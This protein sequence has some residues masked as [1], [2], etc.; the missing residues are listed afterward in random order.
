MPLLYGIQTVTNRLQP[1]HL[2]TYH[3][4][5]FINFQFFSP[6][7]VDETKTH[8]FVICIIL[9]YLFPSHY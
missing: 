5:F 2:L 3:G 8:D 7:I 4:F 9:I 6:Q 1:P